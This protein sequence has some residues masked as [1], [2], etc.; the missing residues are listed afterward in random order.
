MSAPSPRGANGTI[1]LSGIW[2]RV[3]AARPQVPFPEPS[4]LADYLAAGSSIA[5]TPGP[6]DTF[7]KIV[8]ADG[9]GHPSETCVPKT[10]PNQVLLPLPIQIVQS[11]GSN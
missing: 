5:M 8:A 2:T 3:A 9:A 1:D 10:F 11:P 7:R 6:A 4:D